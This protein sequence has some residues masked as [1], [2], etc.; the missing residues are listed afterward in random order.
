MNKQELVGESIWNTY[1]N[2]ASLLSELTGQEAADA[3][4][5][6]D[7][8]ATSISRKTKSG[9]KPKPAGWVPKKPAESTEKITA[10]SS[11]VHGDSD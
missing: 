10:R 8:D 11:A 4:R 1:R 2:M 7:T 9:E 5:D 3:S 6:P